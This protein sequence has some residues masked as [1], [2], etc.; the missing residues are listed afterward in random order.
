[1]KKYIDVQKFRNSHTFLFFS[2]PM[3]ILEQLNIRIWNLDYV[4]IIKLLIEFYIVIASGIIFKLII[5]NFYLKSIFRKGRNLND[6]WKGNWMK[7]GTRTSYYY[8]KVHKPPKVK[9][10]VYFFFCFFFSFFCCIKMYFE[11]IDIWP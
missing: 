1:M 8:I 7:N 6:F 9:S 2:S 5:I 10:Q 11:Q 3:Q 4:Y